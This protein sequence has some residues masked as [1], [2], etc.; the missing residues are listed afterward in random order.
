MKI[1]VSILDCDPLSSPLEELGAPTPCPILDSEDFVI[2]GG[3]AIL[4]NICRVD[5]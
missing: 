2:E 4:I 5:E 3:V 1:R